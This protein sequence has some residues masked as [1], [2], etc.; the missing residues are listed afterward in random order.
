M[1]PTWFR[2]SSNQRP[3]TKALRHK[4]G[5]RG[6]PGRVRLHARPHF[7]L[8]E[9]RVV[10]STLVVNS[11]A[12]TA[13]PAA[14]T[15]TL[16]SAVNQANLAAAA[17]TYDTI[18]FNTAG[19]GGTTITLLNGA[20]ELKAG[21]VKVAGTTT[22]QGA[23][24]VTI[25]GHQSGLIFQVDQGASAALTG[26][27]LAGGGGNV[28]TA[29]SGATINGAPT[30]MTTS[31]GGAVN[32]QGNLTIT[33]CDLVGNVAGG[34]YSY[35][36]AIA[37]S[38]TLTL[39]ASTLSGN[40]AT[41]TAGF[42][43][44][45]AVYNTGTLTLVDSTVANNTV[46]TV[47][48]VGGL[49][50]SPN[51]GG[52]GGILNLGTLT[53]SASTLAGNSAPVGG[54]IDSTSS[55]KVTLKDTIVATDSAATAADISG[56][57]SGNNNLVGVSTG[58]SGIANGDANANRVGTL[59][60]PLNPLLGTLAN[61]GGPVPTMALL[62]GSPALAHGA[63][64]TGVTI[65]GRSLPRPTTT[66]PDIGAFQ[67]QALYALTISTPAAAIADAAF[68][69]TI[70]A[71]DKYGDP[72]TSYNGK[73]TLA[74]SDK[75][76]AYV[77][78]SA[79]NL[80]NGT[81]TVPVT[82][83]TPDTV[84]LTATSSVTG[85]SA[86][87]VVSP[88]VA[89]FA[90]AVPSAATAGTAFYVTIT[91]EDRS[92]NPVVQHQDA[93]G[94]T[95]PG[96][97]GMVTLTAG[98]GQPLPGLTAP[99]A[100][101]NGTATVH[102][103]LDKADSNVALTA[104]AGPV[105]GTSSL[106]AV[107]PAGAYAFTVAAPAPA[108]AGQ[109][110]AVNLTAVD[111][112][113]NVVTS[114]SGPVTL[115]SS[116]G[117]SVAISPATPVWS[118]GT[119][120]VTATI[121]NP[122][123]TPI[124]LK[125]AAKSVS[126][127]SGPIA[128]EATAYASISSG[129]AGLVSW[130][131]G[132]TFPLVDA[133]G[134]IQNGL[135]NALQ[136]GLV[137]PIN[138]HLAQGPSI[139]FLTNG[140]FLSVLQGLG[141]KVGGLTVAVSGV[142]QALN[143]AGTQ[144]TYSL[145]FQATNTAAVPLPSLGTQADRLG[146]QL[147]PSLTVDATTSVN[148]NFSFTIGLASPYAFSFSAPAGGLSASVTINASNVSGAIA[149]G[150]LGGAIAG[151]TVQMNAQ[152]S[153]AS[154]L[155]SVTAANLPSLALSPS[156]SLKVAL[157]VT[158]T[159]GTQTASGTVTV[160]SSNL[161][162]TA[163]T[164]TFSQGLSGWQD[165]G[166]VGADEVLGLLNQLGA[167]L[168]QAATQAWAAKMQE[169]PFL[170]SLS[171]SQAAN[172]GQMFQ[173]EVTSQLETWSATQQ[174]EMPD[175]TTAQGLAGL[176]AQVLDVSPSSI[177]VAFNPT[178]NALTYQLSL[179][180]YSFSALLAQSLQ[181]N[182]N[183]GTLANA[184]LTK[185][186]LSLVPEITAN[187]TVGLDFS[188]V[189]HG[190]TLTPTTTL[191][192]L[193]GGAGVRINASSP[194]L[195]VT[196]TDGSSFQVSL[197]GAKT[198]QDVINDIEKA[199]GGKVTV[200]IDSTSPQ[201]LD[202]TQ[203]APIP[204]SWN[205]SPA[206]TI[207][208][209]NGSYAA[210]DLGIAGTDSAGTGTI[211]GQS[212]SGDSLRKHIFAQNVTIQASVVGTASQLYGAADLAAVSL[213]L[214]NGTGTIN[215]QGSLTIAGPTT[216]DQLTLAVKQGGTTL[217]TLVS[218][219]VSG[220]AKISL[221]IA[222]AAPLAGFT[223]P[224]GAAV[225]VN[226]T[227]ITNPG[228]LTVAV[229]P[230]LSLSNITIQPVL[231]GLQG[232]ESYVQ[233]AAASL[234]SQ[235][236]PG[237]GTSLANVLNPA[238]LLGSALDS[239][240]HAAPLTLDQ[241]ASELGALLGRPVTVS[242]SG[243]VLLVG[244]NYTV[245][246]SQNVNLGFNLSSSLG[247]IAD[248]NGSAP[249]SLAA[250][251]TVT[252]GLA[253]DFT[254]PTSPKFSLQDSSKIAA[255]ALVNGS[256]ITFNATVGPLGIFIANGT[257]RL[258]NGTAGQA[259]TW[260][261]GLAA[262]TTNHL[263]PLSSASSE[264]TSA[265]KGQVNIVLPTFYPTPS[266]PLDPTTPNIE[267]HVTDITQ[268]G[269]T[270]TTK[271]PN[272]AAATSN[273]N[274]S[275]LLDEIV[276]GWDG[277]MRMFRSA[278]TK[279]I[280]ATSLPLVGKQLQQALAFLQTM[281]QKVTGLLES[282]PQ[283]AAS[284]VQDAI[285]QALGPQG[286]NWLVNLVPGGAATENN[287]VQLVQSGGSAH[288]EIQLH[289]A[290]LA[291]SAPVA[292][293]LGLS[294]LG[295]SINGN[296][297]LDAGFDATLGFGVSSQYG[298]YVD[299]ADKASVS[300][301]AG[302]PTSATATLGFL[303]FNVTNN[304]PQ[305]P[306]LSGGLSL[307]LNNVDGT[308][309]LSLADLASTSAYT[310]GLNANANLNLHLAAT[311]D[312]N[313]NLPSISTDL[314]FTWSP[315]PTASNPDALGFRNVTYS[316]GG[317]IDD[318]IGEIDSV[319]KPVM[320]LIDLLS[321]PLPVLSQL[322]G[323]NMDLVD[324]ASTLGFI[325]PGTASF[326]DSVDELIA[327]GLS[328]PPSLDLGSFTLDPSAAQDPTQQGTL[329]PTSTNIT[330]TYTGNPV[331]G[332]QIPI[333]SNPASAFQLLL[334]KD[335][336]LVTY[337]MPQLSFNFGF[338]Q[339]FPVIGPLG[340]DLAGQIG[341]SAQFGFGFDTSGF[342]QYAASDFSDASLI[343]DGFYV[344]N[345]QNPDGTGPVVPQVQLY[346]SIAAYA[347][348]DVG[349]A[350]A[351][352]GGGLFAS[353]NFTLHDPSDTG[354]I[355]L[356]DLEA[357]VQKGT[358][359][360]ASGDL[361]AF[362]NAYVK[363]GVGPFSHTWNYNIAT[364][365]LGQIGEPAPSTPAVPQ[366]ATQS[367]G[368]LQL[369]VGPYAAQRLYGNTADGNET[370]TVTPG[371]VANSVYV[372][373]FG[374]TN[375]EY[376]NVN[377]ITAE[378]GAGNDNITINAGN[379]IDVDLT[380]GGGTNTVNVQSARNV[381]V[382][383]GAGSDNLTI[384]ASGNV[385]VD[386]SATSGADSVNVESASSA[387][388][389]G[390]GGNNSITIGGGS[391]VDV[392]LGSGGGTN[393]VVVQN[394]GNVTLT[395]GAGN[396]SITIGASGNVA[397]DLSAGGGPDMI[398]VQGASGVTVV[399]G[400]GNN[401]VTVGARSDGS[402]GVD[403]SASGGTDSVGVQ[404]AAKTTV[405]AGAG[406]N[407]ITVGGGTVTLGLG[408]SGGTN[409]VVV[410]NAG[411]VTLTGGSG[412]DTLQ[413]DNAPAATI[414]GGSG[415]ETVVVQ[416][417]GNVTF[418]GGTGNSTVT[419][420]A[421]GN[422]NVGLG[423]SLGTNKV[424]VQS[425]GHVTITGG[426]GSDTL[427]VDSA[428]GA[429]I[430]GG[431]GAETLTVFNDGGAATLQA[432]SG[433]DALYAGSGAGQ[434]LDGGSGKDLLVAGSGAN[435]VL[436]G[437]S[438]VS[439]LV[440]GSGAGQQLYGDT[441]TTSIFGG[442]G[443][444][445]SLSAGSGNADLYAGEAAGQTLVG[446]AGIDVLQVGWH[447]MN[448]TSDTAYI[449]TNVTFTNPPQGASQSLMSYQPLQVG[450]HLS[451]TQG[452]GGWTMTDYTA[453]DAS[454]GA[455]YAYLMKAGPGNTLIIGGRGND[456]IDGGTGSDTLY[457]GGGAGNKWMYA[458][459]GPTVM[460]G[461]G[462][463]DNLPGQQ[464][465]GTHYLY[466]G[467]GQDVLYG[468]DG[469]N[470][471]VNN[472]GTGLGNPGGDDGDLGLNILVS[473]SV[474]GSSTT[475]YSDDASL[476]YPSTLLAGSGSDKL[477]AGGDAGD[478][479]EAGIGVDSLYGGLG[480]DVFQL[481][482]I[483][484]GQQAATP[485]TLIGGGGLTTLLLK[486]FQTV[487]KNGQFTQVG[488]NTLGPDNSIDLAAVTGTTNQFL[489]KLSDL[490]SG[491]LVGQ[492]QFTLS[493]TVERIALM[494]GLGDNQI[495][496]ESSV[497]RGVLLY[498]GPGHNI[499]VGNAGNDVLIGGP[500][501]S[502]LEG[503]TGNDS[504]YGGSIPAAYQGIINSLGAG[505]GGPVAGGTT[506]NAMMTWLRKQPTGH[507]IL[508]AGSGNSELFAGDHGD[509]LIG[510]NAVFNSQSGQF[511]LQPGAGRD[512]L[513]GGQGSDLMIGGL[514]AAGDAMIAGAGNS[515]LIG[516]QGQDILEGGG[517]SDVLVGGSLINMMMSNSTGSSS[518]AL[519]GGN[520]LNYEFAGSGNDRLFDYSNP[521]D[522]LQ[523]G[524]WAT[525]DALAAQ[526]HL[527][528]PQASSAAAAN[529]QQEI[530]N[531]LDTLNVLNAEV[532]DLN[533]LAL[534]PQ[535]FGTLTQGSNTISNLYY[536]SA[537]GTTTSG[538]P[539]V[540]VS[541]QDAANLV[542][543][544]IVTG[545]GIPAGVTIEKI[546]PGISPGT[547]QILLNKPATSSG[548]NPLEF[549]DNIIA[550]STWETG[551]IASGS[552][553]ITGLAAP[554]SAAG[555]TTKGS[556]YI[557]NASSSATLAIGE[558]V[559]GTGIPANTIITQIVSGVG[560]EQT[561]ELSNNA[562]ATS[563]GSV[564]LTISSH[565][566]VGLPVSGP[567]IPAG[568]TIASVISGT[569][570][571]LS[572]NATAAATGELFDFGS[573]PFAGPIV[574]AGG[575]AIPAG[576][577][578]T[579]VLTDTSVTLAQPAA[580]SAANV[581][582]TFA[583]TPEEGKQ[584]TALANAIQTLFQELSN[585]E[586]QLGATA[587]MDFMQGGS[588][589]DS[590]YTS[591]APVWMIGG[592][593]GS[594]TYYI[595]PANDANFTKDL[596]QSAKTAN[597]TLMFMGDG[598]IQLA[599]NSKSTSDVATINGTALS[600][601]EAPGITTVGV[602]TM[603]GYD[604]VTIGSPNFGAYTQS[605]RVVDGGVAG[606]PG[607]EGDVVVDA[608]QLTEN[609]TLLGGAGNDTFMIGNPHYIQGHESVVEGGTGNN[610]RNELE[611]VGNINGGT[612]T[613]G[614]D[615]HTNQEGI[616]TFGGTWVTVA[617]IQTLVVIGGSAP[618]STAVT[619]SVVSDGN[620]IPNLIM[621]GGSGTN[622]TN[623]FLA[624]GGTNTM[625]GGAALA[626]QFTAT[627]G[628]NMVIGGSGTDTMTVTGGTST[629]YGGSGTNTMTVTAGTATLFGGGGENDI[630]V[631]GAGS[632]TIYGGAG[633]NYIDA[634]GGTSTI[635]GGIGTN[636]YFLYGAGTYSLAGGLG[637]N[638]LY[639]DCTA[640]RDWLNLS[641]SGPTI[642]VNG[643]DGGQGITVTASNMNYVE[644][645]GSEAGY[646]TLSASGMI[647]GVHLVGVGSYNTLEG[648]AG[649]DI[650][651]CDVSMGGGNNTLIAG[652]NSDRLY[653]SGDGSAY[654]G[655]GSNTLVYRA[656]PSDNVVVYGNGLEIDGGLASGTY[657]SGQPYTYLTGTF[658]S[659]AVINGV[660]NIE[661]EDGTGTATARLATS[662]DIPSYETYWV[663]SSASTVATLSDS[664]KFGGDNWDWFVPASWTTFSTG[665]NASLS[666][667]W[668]G[669]TT[670]SVSWGNWVSSTQWPYNPVG[671]SF[672][673]S[674][675]VASGSSLATVSFTLT[676]TGD[677]GSTYW[678]D[679]SGYS[680]WSGGVQVDPGIRVND[681]TVQATG[682]GGA[683]VNYPENF[684]TGG[685]IAETSGMSYSIP[686]PFTFPIGT[687]QVTAT[688]TD[689]SQ[690][691]STATFNV[692]VLP[693]APITVTS[694]APSAVSGQ[695][696]TLTANLGE[697]GPGGVTPTG[698]VTFMDG[699]TVI[700][701][702][703]PKTVGG[704]TTATFTTS[705][706]AVGSH[707]IT[708]V[709][710]GDSNF[711]PLTSDVLLQ[712]VAQDATTTT[713]TESAA[714]TT[715]QAVTF[716]ATVLPAAP[717]GGVPTGSIQ[718]LLDGVAYGKPVAL[719][720]GT[721]T[722]TISQW[723][724]GA[725]TI[726]AAYS[727]DVN[728]TGS[729][730]GTITTYAGTGTQ[731]S[732]GDGGPA[733]AAQLAA[734]G[735]LVLD[736]AGDLFIADTANNRVQEVIRSTGAIITV[737][738]NGTA[739]YAGDGGKATAAELDDPTAVAVDSAGDLF[740]A[741]L[742]N[743]VIR[744]VVAATGAII[745]YAGNG[746]AGSGGDGGPAK[747]AQ[748]NGIAALALDAS[749]DLFIADSGNNRIREVVHS[750][751][752]IQT[753]AGTGTRGDGGDGG[754]ATAALLNGP[755]GLAV[756]A[757]GDLFISDTGNNRVREVT[758]GT[759]RTVAGT[760][761]AGFG[762]DG[763][764]ATLATLDGPSAIAVDALG[765]LL[766]ADTLNN[767]IREVLA[768][769]GTIIT[770]AGHGSPNS[771]GD[772]G[773]AAAAEIDVPDGLAVWGRGYLFVSE[774]KGNRVRELALN[775]RVS[776]L[777][778]SATMVSSSLASSVYGQ[779]VTLKTTVGATTTGTGTP[780]GSVKFLDGTKVLGIVNLNA[781]GT[782]AL[783]LTMLGAG[784]HSITAVYNGD[785]TF[786][787]STSGALTQAVAQAQSTTALTASTTTS[788]YGQSVTFTATIKAVSPG[789]GTATFTDK[790]TNTVLGTAT[791][792]GGVASLSTQALGVGSHT[793]VA[794]YGGDANFVASVSATVT[795]TVK[796]A[797]TATALSASSTSATHGTAITFTAAVAVVSPGTG[798]P[799]GS[800]AFYL[801]GV[802]IM[803]LV[804]LDNTGKAR[805][806]IST[807]TSGTHQITAVYG[808]NGN[809]LTSTSA[810][811]MVTIS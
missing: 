731:G 92:G 150:F 249:L 386:L 776:D 294:G 166:N 66:A 606:T 553:T 265:I 458:G 325:S 323:H 8:L 2:P 570:I 722:L 692:T 797:S 486:P 628:T 766:I 157:P 100:L 495:V 772:G 306:Q 161:A 181:I 783:T 516:S 684:S 22:I 509:L 714:T 651:E 697:T 242:L 443:S 284:T 109:G 176:L 245:S 77:S 96:Y 50:T 338:D 84:A 660:S 376:T 140:G 48:P 469:V 449:G 374:V 435:Q 412:S 550:A 585:A 589:T 590:L 288:Y 360:D 268:P 122:D 366:L 786:Q 681:L 283:L 199:S 759:I 777:V 465:T 476:T 768:G 389:T 600:W 149:I 499:L 453:G 300:F 278:L 142:T 500:G 737:A 47:A 763:A 436:H 129:L 127:Q 343:L 11:L 577:T 146:I 175:F 491:T 258:D 358:I 259:A 280:N 688:A 568:T 302:L 80:I 20:L 139:S 668:S 419:I 426:S 507:N 402:V 282:A 185:G 41:A 460:Y 115:T 215:A 202:V 169:L 497:Q 464:V 27:T 364:V 277:L 418:A 613:E 642:T 365:T 246:A 373:G 266:Q 118:G 611:V 455:G 391:S 124:T 539:I 356:Q 228:T 807:L 218:P 554:I 439:T 521:N 558:T 625:I 226:W 640:S 158:A 432:G 275:A 523:A 522:P 555:V 143:S 336:P 632:Y 767:R 616:E 519:L 566:T 221:P 580:Q 108:G 293:N 350:S 207:A 525:V 63:A 404:G 206:F 520:G 347:A 676:V 214:N 689:G 473:G 806:T 602:Q 123:S 291:V 661:I 785:A 128:L 673:L 629:L 74:S 333:L 187:L 535:Q 434:V 372:S 498:G 192:S 299:A 764:S 484:V 112:Y 638:S 19:M 345:R 37:N 272:F 789:A 381:T 496:S 647:M 225:V 723:V 429:T 116:D 253:V 492:V 240:V 35:G 528:L 793:I 33:Q 605:I 295:L 173:A 709:Y 276:G 244:L 341:A 694:S 388:V 3:G 517:G 106:F 54:G 595:T 32:N 762:G 28:V 178:T 174:Q 662:S 575:S 252:M 599:Y 493:S 68:P 274:S 787:T 322:A 633:A 117:Q 95:I 167:E 337:E 663:S 247:S 132:Q 70:T 64:I 279:Q 627:G 526:Y 666:Y 309:R 656:Q 658:I 111:P 409:T 533:T 131:A 682:P 677:V 382:T 754:A 598:N 710:G 315:N 305:T 235:P 506:S 99:I 120:T 620:L 540:T 12:D 264:I 586:G 653:V 52:G 704:V 581:Q 313:T 308:G 501:T 197:A 7:E 351:G 527:A 262:S 466:G 71:V 572:S 399:G 799:T 307:G 297:S 548:T 739:G 780:T 608:T 86:S 470:I 809:D 730:S 564:L 375:Q 329:N 138:A 368:D 324:L 596:I 750:T 545:T 782:A 494:G 379:N 200:A 757:A 562:T 451:E 273:I 222:L 755:T 26:L 335:V 480:S 5:K 354:E 43:G 83:A 332:F 81:A 188:P 774:A 98:D 680:L 706:L 144:I 635:I 804:T 747:K 72:V 713:V 97:S 344:S 417:A 387:T 728:F 326:I 511:V 261:L 615:P 503:G 657:S 445:Q 289:Q 802:E 311:I 456:T 448:G 239:V 483:P 610:Q 518:S 91:A 538:S 700:G 487:L 88:P 461:G 541:A 394:A 459:T 808:G 285:Y 172:I 125:A 212:L 6:L 4:A 727:G 734:P 702:G 743:D 725:H 24:Q 433:T 537:S 290:L 530:Q 529:L 101:I 160:S 220:T 184:G 769:S 159:L 742:G 563:T 340:V 292:V 234:L 87:I 186:Q 69:V 648:G 468:G 237:F 724:L 286:L 39:N 113:G 153:N 203:V 76:T 331:T 59:A 619:N 583:L 73:A 400:A 478:Y 711:A 209:I 105:Q 211:D 243:N 182:L 618:D 422:V 612:V 327:G 726:S 114:Y 121:N 649:P 532:A 637:R 346:G 321:A 531:S 319:L 248:V 56:V 94:N 559:T 405:T 686:S 447:L 145:D 255:T 371:P 316:M 201:G 110:F 236:L 190:F 729:S 452:T 614:I 334:G 454:Q 655:T 701:T 34:L 756:D 515:V 792:S 380:T 582:L 791:L 430:T 232:V 9:D 44:G 134:N 428:A 317:F 678:A 219:K 16:R 665:D 721:A 593:T 193:N 736:A 414:T 135:Q 773:P 481:P 463:G 758:G 588:G 544:E 556:P 256:G 571:T 671:I 303:Q 735:G 675:Y 442:T 75:Q 695:S 578:V 479:L 79:I 403:L 546:L 609:A 397:V 510:G 411:G 204:A 502:L 270:T 576:D 102:V 30:P 416:G 14:G 29:G 524:A 58:L 330:S 31:S 46:A 369:N 542:K 795:E 622:A 281:D 156:S 162:T 667:S 191:A 765:D 485:D 467:S 223:L 60:A 314:Y 21:S 90:V 672:V 393:T 267:L 712:S 549:S 775:A 738:G 257:A 745:T 696:V 719:S 168:G 626:N 803:P 505:P 103:V 55:G 36:G 1:R 761:T 584:Q 196:M 377:E 752:N 440:G 355:H 133:P 424:D 811:V 89:T 195:Q 10:L 705:A 450:W 425:A 718:F 23:G 536:E 800:V 617:G 683:V 163:P 410:Q 715:G 296:A 716:T 490:D 781:A 49:G 760:G 717:G 560:G 177:V 778:T 462:P 165:L 504:L 312:G 597:D 771:S 794:S 361:Q 254:Q 477:Y 353:A 362:L 415:T 318:I 788:V 15:V 641:Q 107:S 508:I 17:G 798:V 431:S 482:F 269:S 650:L 551:T 260:N 687:T 698:Q 93:Y 328:V 348:L 547:S 623:T 753:V 40:S 437:G 639:V 471:A 421:T 205:G 104:A 233:G 298:F 512:V 352:V 674:G 339:F 45:G 136:V 438:G 401:T 395:G 534:H 457:G 565:L 543:G 513:E 630:N 654:Y 396:D 198:I 67:S 189:G 349:V 155:S 643:I 779:S 592:V 390:G 669:S 621:E 607:L 250:G 488:L 310:I 664:A 472:T 171:L 720:G 170:P 42:G 263:W 690:R 342:R 751:G 601:T 210:A 652:N 746:A 130:A 65:D 408:T 514:G 561:I 707:T 624:S 251:A 216:L 413:V 604:R 241:L 770:L 224:S 644:A 183:Q 406:N 385:G 398:A 489:A 78:A 53:A 180:D 569:S 744:E 231:Q 213:L 378:G 594:H 790:T 229:T 392:V 25:N 784:S 587:I 796:P 708:A 693:V 423:A 194:D 810:T 61:Y 573:L 659:F 217:S 805:W 230:A 801:D 227:D 301:T 18:T 370:L 446:G 147:N 679:D 208:A 475:I 733:T 383:G 320:P 164:V 567:G 691:T 57:V 557:T 141:T 732:A 126:G 748:F 359:F 603:G 407:S 154:A 151:G 740:I 179:T 271:V 670:P 685:A 552:N 384:A 631:S 474:A 62:T 420:G 51:L 636:A 579:S 574:S 427:E 363:V 444:G 82:L 357:D 119:T 148:F 13:N 238:A 749:G 645:D 703:T 38:G 441:S 287:Y 699:S 137:N 646:D 367:D 304:A 152:E 591:T 85:T 741:D 634:S